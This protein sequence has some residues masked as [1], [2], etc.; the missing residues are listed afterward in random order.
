MMMTQLIIDIERYVAERKSARRP[1]KESTFGRLAVNDGKL[2]QRL[3]AGGEVMPR[4]ERRIREFMEENPVT[5]SG[6]EA[7]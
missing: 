7:A 1:I 5:A 4:T 2:L 6:E 3:R